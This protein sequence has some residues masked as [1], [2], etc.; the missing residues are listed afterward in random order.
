VDLQ[1]F[2]AT[3][4]GIAVDWP[5]AFVAAGT[6]GVL[7]LDLRDPDGPASAYYDTPGNARSVSLSGGVLAVAD[8][9]GG[10]LFF[11]VALSSAH[12]PRLVR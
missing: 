4:N 1:P 3:A 6:G 8:E 5:Y 2:D 7:V 11:R 9:A 12:L 10:L